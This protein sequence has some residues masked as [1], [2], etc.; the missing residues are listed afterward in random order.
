MQAIFSY[1]RDV[2][3]D[4][5]ADQ[6]PSTPERAFADWVYLGA[7]P[8]SRLHPPPLDIDF[9]ELDRDRVGRLIQAMG[10]QVEFEAWLERYNAYQADDDVQANAATSMVF[11]Y[12]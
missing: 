4:R 11:G 2:I 8:R 3:C 12:S 5:K 6:V 9:H 10:I 1:K 7:S